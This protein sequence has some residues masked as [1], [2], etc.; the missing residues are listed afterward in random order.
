[1]DVAGNLTTR[2]LKI[3]FFL[4]ISRSVDSEDVLIYRNIHIILFIAMQISFI[5]DANRDRQIDM[6]LYYQRE[7]GIFSFS[8]L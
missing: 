2:K 4:F 7:W 6:L 5:H 8:L 3:N 1:M